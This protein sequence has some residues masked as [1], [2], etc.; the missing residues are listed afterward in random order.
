MHRI[1]ITKCLSDK[2]KRRLRMFCSYCQRRKFRAHTC[3]VYHQTD[4]LYQTDTY[5]L[6][7]TTYH[8]V[9]FYYSKSETEEEVLSDREIFQRFQLLK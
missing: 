3:V 4:T 5:L 6:D 1:V 8:L 7:F 2:T 9:V